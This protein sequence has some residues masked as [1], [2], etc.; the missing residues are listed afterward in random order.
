[1][2]IMDVVVII[3]AYNEGGT[4]RQ[5]VEAARSCPL[6]DEVVVVSDGSTDRTVAEAT[7][8]GARVIALSENQ[9]KGAAMY[10]G[11]QATSQ[12]VILFL[13]GDLLGLTPRHVE[14]L[15]Q[16]ILEERA[17]MAVGIF[18]TGRVCTDLAQ[19]IA[20]HLSGQRALRR[21]ALAG[22]PG[23]QEAGFGVETLITQYAR[24]MGWRVVTISLKHVSHRLKEEK[25]GFLKGLCTRFSMYREILKV[26]FSRGH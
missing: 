19:R 5:V 3:P 15:L 25:Q 7:A 14:K 8:A 4:V 10:A 23:F 20:P 13:D 9:G 11:L 2:T 24:G 18:D 16:P 12:E 21:S 1:M 6:V 26:V 22:A 17:D